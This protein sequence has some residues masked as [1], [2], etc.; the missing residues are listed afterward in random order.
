MPILNDL[1]YGHVGLKPNPLI[2]SHAPNVTMSN[3][4]VPTRIWAPI[5][6]ISLFVQ[7]DG[8]WNIESHSP[9][10]YQ[11]CINI[12]PFNSV[13]VWR[14]AH[15][16]A[17]CLHVWNCLIQG[18][19]PVLLRWWSTRR[20]MPLPGLATLCS[21]R[22]SRTDWKW[23]DTNATSDHRMFSDITSHDGWSALHHVL[24]SNYHT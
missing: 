15:P 2:S 24:R 6:L 4:A 13:P 18:K 1:N 23:N 3:S 20:R 22:Y 19:C 5:I 12:D 8:I 11:W 21:D 7:F 14:R 16:S 10:N 17:A 9:S